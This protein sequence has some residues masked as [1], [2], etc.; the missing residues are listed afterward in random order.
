V[1]LGVVAVEAVQFAQF[2]EAVGAVRFEDVDVEVAADGAQVFVEA[3]DHVAAGEVAVDFAVGAAIA[4]VVEAEDFLDL[5]L[6]A[7]RFLR[8]PPSLS[9]RSIVA[10]ISVKIL[11]L[12]I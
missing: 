7:F 4:L 1:V 11:N 8:P 2:V 9:N 3:G 6:A 5:D 10:L 12:K